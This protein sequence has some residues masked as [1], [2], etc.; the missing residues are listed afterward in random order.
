MKRLGSLV[1][2]NYLVLQARHRIGRCFARKRIP[3]NWHQDVT[4]YLA[5]FGRIG[6]SKANATR[7]EFNAAWE[8]LKA[9]TP[10]PVQP[11]EAHVPD[12]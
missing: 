7:E 2:S 3:G 1:V 12:S 8:T 9:S 10:S 11:E 5:A 4:I 6:S